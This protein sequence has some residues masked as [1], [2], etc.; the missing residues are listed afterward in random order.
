MVSNDKNYSVCDFIEEFGKVGCC[1]QLRKLMFQLLVLSLRLR[2]RKY[3]L[4][5]CKL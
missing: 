4:F 1:E 5:G 3:C 2:K